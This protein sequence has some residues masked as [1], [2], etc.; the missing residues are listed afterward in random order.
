[1][2]ASSRPGVGATC[3]PGG[4]TFRT[5][6][7]FALAV[8]VVGTGA[9]WNGEVSLSSE[10]C[11]YWSVDVPGAGAGDQYAF[12]LTTGSHDDI[13]RADPRSRW[14]VSSI[15]NAIVYA[16]DAY[17]WGVDAYAT[18]SWS[19]AVIYEMHV[20]TFTSNGASPGTLQTAITKFDYLHDLGV[21][22][23]E[24]LPVGEFGGFRSKGYNT[25]LPFAV[26]SDYGGPDALKDFVREADRRGIAVVADVIYNHWGAADLERSLWRYDGWSE[27]GGGGIYFYNDWRAST[28]WQSPR[29]DYGRPEVRDFIVE[30]VLMWLEEFR[31]D[32]L[33]FDQTAQMWSA[34]GT[35]LLDG[36][37]LLQQITSSVA[38]RQPWKILIA[39]DFARGAQLTDPVPWGGA[40]FGAQ[41]DQFV[42]EV[43]SALTTAW[44]DQR[45]LVEVASA[46]TRRSGTGA[47]SR[48]I[49]TESHDEDGNG[50]Q[51]LPEEISRHQ[52]T[53]DQRRSDPPSAAPLCSLLPASRC[54]SRG[55]SFSRISGGA[56][57]GRSTGPRWTPA[58][59]SYGSTAIWFSSDATTTTRLA[60]CPV[61][62]CTC[63]I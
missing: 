13:R 16:G 27:N 47:F 18:P 52:Q 33:R 6:A 25:M 9:N 54:S 28:P 48:V 26:E 61:K 14:V 1:M 3:Y 15:G 62:A 8:R 17:D 55:R 5:W 59:E 63:I 45:N 34:S 49:Y 2:A 19:A 38:A 21:N 7:P 20:G 43:R 57:T 31:L 56:T 39:E 22:V 30:N 35:D 23:I 11:G 4:V 46:L 51:R 42:H 29:P 50:R 24:I 58:P 40:G 10:P 41:W 32:G 37:W 12:L 44:D 60:D 36:W 53:A